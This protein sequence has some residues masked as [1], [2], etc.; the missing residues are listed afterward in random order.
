MSDPAS[1]FGALAQVTLTGAEIFDAIPALRSLIDRSDLPATVQYRLGRNA[2]ALQREATAI[3]ETLQPV[4]KAFVRLD[5]DGNPLTRTR[6][7]PTGEVVSEPVFTDE[8]AAKQA[9]KEVLDAAHEVRLFV[10]DAAALIEHQVSFTPA[11]WMTLD[12]MF[13]LLDDENGTADSGS[14]PERP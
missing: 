4:V 3:Q 9:Q 8:A 14:I 11:V 13:S 2:R 10:F 1:P 6:G 12:F 5:A 7:L